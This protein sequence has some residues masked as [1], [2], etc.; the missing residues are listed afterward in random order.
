[1]VRGVRARARSILEVDGELRFNTQA[2][3]FVCR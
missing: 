3:A 2:G 1:V